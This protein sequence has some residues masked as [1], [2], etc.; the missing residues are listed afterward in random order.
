MSKLVVAEIEDAA[1]GN[2]YSISLG[3]DTATAS[4][5]SIDFTSIP[6]G[7]REINIMFEA[8]SASGSSDILVQIGDGGGIE[9]AGYVSLALEVNSGG[10]AAGN[11]TAGFQIV[12]GNSASNVYRGIIRLLLKDSANFTWVQSGILSRDASTEYPSAGVK[13]LTAELDRV[14]ITHANGSDT[15]DAGSMNINFQ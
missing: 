5:T 2:P 13:S 14:R 8:V 10:T 1:G 12:D 6:A 9:S 4:G 3:T 7:V 15:F 11:S